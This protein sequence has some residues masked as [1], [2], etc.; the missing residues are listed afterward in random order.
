[1]TEATSHGSTPGGAQIVITGGASFWSGPEGLALDRWALSLTGKERPKV[2]Y[3]P[4]ASGDHPGFVSSFHE[5]LGPH[6]EASVLP[7]FL[8]P[9]RDPEAAVLE[10]DL[11]YVPGGSTANL[12]AVWRRHGLVRM[13]RK[14]VDR[15]TILYGASAGALCWFEA[16]LTDS[17]GFD[18]Q[19]RPL[20]DGLGFLA[21]SHCPHFDRTE[22]LAIYAEL[23]QSGALP[24]GLGVDDHAAVRFVEG[25]LVEVRSAIAGATAVRV[26]RAPGAP[27]ARVTPLEAAP[28]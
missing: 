21:G 11:I 9:Y 13:L 22:R 24:D 17:L 8:P 25:R 2:C 3:L 26:E 10:A 28:I 14:A 20:T 27:T 12:L 18:G 19:L 4:T 1:M 5:H 15:G 6:C 16:G 7:L 23:V